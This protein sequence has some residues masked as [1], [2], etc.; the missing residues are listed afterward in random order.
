MKKLKKI[1]SGVGGRV[2][3]VWVDVNVELKCFVKI[4]NKNWGWG[5]GWW[6]VS[7]GGG[8]VVGGQGGCEGN[9]GCRG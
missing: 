1:E 3:G 6:K 9:A 8:G 5:S 2:E 7:S 4:Q